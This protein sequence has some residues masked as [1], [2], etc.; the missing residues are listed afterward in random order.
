MASR[1]PFQ[2]SGARAGAPRGGAAQVLAG[3][4]GRQEECHE[5]RRGSPPGGGKINGEATPRESFFGSTPPHSAPAFPRSGR[6]FF[7][8]RPHPSQDRERR[9]ARVG[10]EGARRQAGVAS[11]WPSTTRTSFSAASRRA[12]VSPWWG[13]FTPSPS[14]RCGAGGRGA[15]AVSGREARAAVRPGGGR[16]G[17]LAPPSLPVLFL[18]YFDVLPCFMG[19][20][21]AV[22]EEAL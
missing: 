8:R 18:L 15:C 1:G 17:R 2:A 10:G 6:C 13:G 21:P 5:P 9:G 16:G 19:S 4:Y 3:R 20:Y 12:W 11:P 22:G 7:K 14:L